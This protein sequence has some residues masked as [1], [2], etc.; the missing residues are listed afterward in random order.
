MPHIQS[1]SP[2]TN[3]PNQRA[4]IKA[5]M[6]TFPAICPVAHLQEPEHL[7]GSRIGLELRTRQG[8][9]AVRIERQGRLVVVPPEILQSFAVHGRFVT[10]HHHLEGNA[11]HLSILDEPF[12]LQPC[13]ATRTYPVQ[14]DA[15]TPLPFLQ[16]CKHFI[17]RFRSHICC[18]RWVVHRHTTHSPHT[19]PP[20]FQGIKTHKHAQ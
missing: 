16:T 1:C 5:K 2:Q 12:L 10:L 20:M 14:T 6:C 3:T 17:R 15:V 9:G 11:P 18:A 7:G 19:Y 4:D 13:Q 8:H